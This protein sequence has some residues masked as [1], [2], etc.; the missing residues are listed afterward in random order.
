MFHQIDPRAWHDEGWLRIKGFHDFAGSAIV[1]LTG[2]K[3]RRDQCYCFENI[4]TKID[5]FYTKY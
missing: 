3:E 4:F 2:G 1:H 5:G